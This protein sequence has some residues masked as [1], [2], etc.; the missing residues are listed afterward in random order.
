M[1]G[2]AGAGGALLLTLTHVWLRPAHGTNPSPKS[3]TLTLTLT[4][5]LILTYFYPWPGRATTR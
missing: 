3:L 2:A 1:G 5:T 4:L